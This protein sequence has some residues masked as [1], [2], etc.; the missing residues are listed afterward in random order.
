M[1]KNG[2]YFLYSIISAENPLEIPLLKCFKK[3]YMKKLLLKK[4]KQEDENIIVALNKAGLSK[5][6]MN[7]T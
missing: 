2:I 4:F 5:Y 7:L 1:I 6:S 3:V